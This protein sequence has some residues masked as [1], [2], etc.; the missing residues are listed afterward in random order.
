MFHT[1]TYFTYNAYCGTTNAVIDVISELDVGLI[2][3]DS[4]QSNP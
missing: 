4:I 2:F 3:R 1:T